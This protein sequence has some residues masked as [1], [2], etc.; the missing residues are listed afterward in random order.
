MNSRMMEQDEV[1]MGS[2]VL[3]W[4]AREHHLCKGEFESEIAQ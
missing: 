2:P 3:W 1:G 4:S